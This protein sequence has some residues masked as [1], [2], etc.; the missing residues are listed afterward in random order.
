MEIFEVIGLILYVILGIQSG[1]YAR[2]LNRNSRNWMMLSILL[3]PLL[4]LVIL[5]IMGPKETY[6]ADDYPDKGIGN[7]AEPTP[8]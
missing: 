7:P 4:S 5:K 8:A 1:R 2:K 6:T 3:S